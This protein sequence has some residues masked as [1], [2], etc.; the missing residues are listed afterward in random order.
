M[1]SRLVAHLNPRTHDNIKRVKLRFPSKR[2]QL[3]CVDINL[4]TYD[5]ELEALKSDRNRLDITKV[6]FSEMKMMSSTFVSDII[7]NTHPT[8]L[9][10]NKPTTNKKKYEWMVKVVHS[11][12]AGV[13]KIPFLCLNRYRIEAKPLFFSFFFLGNIFAICFLRFHSPTNSKFIS[14]VISVT[15]PYLSRLLRIHEMRM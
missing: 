9:Y 10:R 6:T 14:I 3:I 15:Q 13:C 7:G 8:Q 5:S 2:P 12:N 11:Q 1:T 4:Y